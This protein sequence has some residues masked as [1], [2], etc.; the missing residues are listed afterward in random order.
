MK[1]RLPNIILSFLLTGFVFH[2]TSCGS[3]GKKSQEDFEK[4]DT[5]KIVTLYGPTS[6][7]NY[8]EEIMGID[9]DNVIKFAEDEG[10]VAQVIVKNNI[11]ELIDALK[12]GEAHLA[13]YPVPSIGEYKDEVI[14]CGEAEVSRQVLLQKKNDKKIEDVTQLIGKEIFVEPDSKY[15]Y[16]LRNLDDELGGGII[17]KTLP[18]DTLVMEDLLQM[19]RKGEID[20]TVV[21]SELMSVYKNAYPDLDASV[22][23][24]S[25]QKSSWA[26]AKGLDSLANEIDIWEKNTDSPRFVKEIYKRYYDKALNDNFDTK[27]SYF[28]KIDFSKNQPV[29][30]YDEYF[31][32]YSSDAGFDWT[33]LAAIAYCES[34]FNPSATSVFGASGLMQVMPSSARAFGMDPSSLTLPEQN[35]KTASLI[36]NNLNKSLEKRVEDP[37]ERIKFVVA[38]YNSGLGHIFDAMALAEKTG[39]DPQKWIGNVSIAA[40][41]KSRPEYYNDPVVKHGY[42][43]GRETTE[44]VEH[45]MSIYKYLRTN[46]TGKKRI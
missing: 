34:G 38:A 26:V 11:N 8:R 4:I 23:L 7:F 28:K 40:L 20:Y 46:V 30:A 5:L 6:Y 42:F 37:E 29:S 22:V 14:Y 36:L 33:L 25:D 2:F 24:S 9:Y 21:D 12:N 44:F 32:K 17:I 1:K 18:S 3:F 41:M 35:V 13:A 45:V 27:L 43:R 39:L 19:V 31:K 10:Y 15:Y 16:R